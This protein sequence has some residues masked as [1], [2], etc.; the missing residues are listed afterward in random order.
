ME[1]NLKKKSA[2]KLYFEVWRFHVSNM[3]PLAQ[4]GYSLEVAHIVITPF[5]N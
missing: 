3:S 2:V 1:A 4:S 5:D